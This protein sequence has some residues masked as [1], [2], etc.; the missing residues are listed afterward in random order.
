MRKGSGTRASSGILA[1]SACSSDLTESA[2]SA[3]DTSPVRLDS[4]MH[5]SIVIPAYNEARRLP[6]TLESWR[7][8]LVAQPFG[9]EIVVVDDGSSDA[10][11]SVATGPDTRV[12]R[13]QPNRGKGCAVKA[14][15]LAASGDV[16]AY[17]DADLNISPS[18]LSAALAL[19][20]KG[21]DLV[22][23]R[24]DLAEYAAA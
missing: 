12:L 17:V 14:G 19:L 10:T 13:L 18:H 24:R 6:A 5:V 21:A 2:T 22:V 3:D 9:S 7:A 20:D 15:V 11:A 16:I 4:T 23:G 8:Y 1:A